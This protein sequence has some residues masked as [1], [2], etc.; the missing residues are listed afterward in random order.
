MN[1]WGQFRVV[2]IEM[3][4]S[5][6]L[7]FKCTVNDKLGHLGKVSQFNQITVNAEIVVIVRYLLL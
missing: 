7:S 2:L 1:I 6:F 4:P 5:A 3:K